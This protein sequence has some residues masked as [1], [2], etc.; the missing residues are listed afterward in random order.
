M[1]YGQLLFNIEGQHCSICM[2]PA[3]VCKLCWVNYVIKILEPLAERQ[4]YRTFPPHM[5]MS[6]AM[7][8]AAE[9]YWKYAEDTPQAKDVGKSF[10]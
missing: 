2:R 8:A 1:D 5:A 6:K 7:S 9:T 10:I 4:A 3:W